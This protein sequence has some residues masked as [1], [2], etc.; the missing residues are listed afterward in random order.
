MT[1]PGKLLSRDGT[2]D[3]AVFLEV[4]PTPDVDW[5]VVAD[6]RYSVNL[7]EHIFDIDGSHRVVV[8]CRNGMPVKP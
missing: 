1:I 8:H 6:M 5:V 7:I 3:H 2:L 4:I